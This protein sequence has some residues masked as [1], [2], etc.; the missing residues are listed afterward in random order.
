MFSF[1]LFLFVC[2][3]VRLCCFESFF[4][5]VSS[6]VCHL[7]SI[8]RFDVIPPWKVNSE[9]ISFPHHNNRNRF[10]CTAFIGRRDDDDDDGSSSSSNSSTIVKITRNSDVDFFNALPLSWHTIDRGCVCVFAVCTFSS[11]QKRPNDTQTISTTNENVYVH[12]DTH[13]MN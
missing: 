9:N 1:C 12:A 5:L 3:A 8:Y 10:T 11:V 13:S 6:I 2:H 7:T 4:F